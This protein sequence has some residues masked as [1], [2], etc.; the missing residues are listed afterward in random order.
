[1]PRTFPTNL[2]TV[3]PSD[4]PLPSVQVLTKRGVFPAPW[5]DAIES[6]GLGVKRVSGV[7]ELTKLAKGD[8][9]FIVLFR[10]GDDQDGGINVLKKL[11]RA[12]EL[13]ALP[14][15]VVGQEG[16]TLAGELGK[17]FRTPFALN[18]PCEPSQI[19]GIVERA[20][21]VLLGEP[22][23]QTESAVEAPPAVRPFASE[24]FAFLR[25]T[26]LDQRA[27]GGARF[28]RRER[29]KELLR[30]T[31]HGDSGLERFVTDLTEVLDNESLA[32][33]ARAT[34]MT[35]RLLL[36]LGVPREPKRAA[37]AAGLWRAKIF[38]ANPRYH[39]RADYLKAS[40]P[41]LRQDLG[42][43]LMGSA[44]AAAVEFGDPEIGDL[45]ISSARLM[46]A[47]NSEE[48]TQLARLAS[49]VVLADLA[50][51][52][53]WGMGFFNSIKAYLLLRRI[54]PALIPGVDIEMLC[55]AAK[56]L[57]EGVVAAPFRRLIPKKSVLRVQDES[58]YRTAGLP[59]ETRILSLDELR[60]GMRLA[61][62]L[63]AHDGR[64]ILEP[65][66][67]LDDD[68]IWRLWRLAS[69]RPVQSSCNIVEE[70]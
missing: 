16:E 65:D 9:S 52:V 63:R 32:S 2:P 8:R 49:S 13:F 19:S 29:Y 36:A 11:M 38:G 1:M 48:G 53:C 43:T 58:G 56:F 61:S 40:G 26:A 18:E 44:E 27:L 25:R 33:T 24:L 4:R 15:I 64:L 34:Y 47:D 50:E 12:T 6:L 22:A 46:N 41:S 59:G 17:V 35:H 69:I 5:T 28:V 21:R 10:Y 68:L 54:D 39:L 20:A 7:P 57:S 66:I 55:C 3:L 31:L 14:L 62:P 45:V 51:R 37:L 42:S 30:E 60:P 23:E 70:P 67:L